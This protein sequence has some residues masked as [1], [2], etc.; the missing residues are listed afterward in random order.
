MLK[1]VGCKELFT[2]NGDRTGQCRLHFLAGQ[3]YLGLLESLLNKPEL[4]TK[5]SGMFMLFS[6]KSA[7]CSSITSAVPLAL[8][9]PGAV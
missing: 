8:L 3:R 5:V 1:I 2:D 9:L 7:T 6:G 4:R